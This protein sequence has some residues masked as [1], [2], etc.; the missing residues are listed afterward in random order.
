MPVAIDEVSAEIVP[1]NPAASGNGK[2]AADSTPQPETVAR[3]LRELNEYL[4]R[5]V[6]RVR[7][8]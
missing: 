8:D 7:A 1:P 6:A 2:R 5:R 3:R 4:A